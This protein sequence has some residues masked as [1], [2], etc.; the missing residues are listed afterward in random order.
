MQRSGQSW[1]TRG[2][3]FSLTFAIENTGPFP[4]IIED[5]PNET[6]DGYAERSSIEIAPLSADSDEPA[7]SEWVTFEPF[8]LRGGDER[9]VRL[10]YRFIECS[11]AALSEQTPPSW[12]S[13]H[14][15]FEFATLNRSAELT[16]LSQL[17]LGGIEQCADGSD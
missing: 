11:P 14:V 16:L 10:T 1:Y 5:F 17:E 4:V 15:A 13:Q 7:E 12:R 2:D 8:M 9:F 3:E 6:I